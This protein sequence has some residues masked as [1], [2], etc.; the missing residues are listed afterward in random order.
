MHSSRF[1][2][3]GAL[4]QGLRVQRVGASKITQMCLPAPCQA[5]AIALPGMQRAQAAAV[6]HQCA[7]GH[8][9]LRLSCDLVARRGPCR[10]PAS[11]CSSQQLSG[12]EHTSGGQRQSC[13]WQVCSLGP[14]QL[15]LASDLAHCNVT[16]CMRA[17]ARA[18][19][20][21]QTSRGLHHY[22][23]A[24]AKLAQHD[25]PLAQFKFTR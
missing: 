10:T 19:S 23:H 18:L 13:R 4:R 6:R 14:C 25:H 15:D 2:A 5:E 9:S 8:W 12:I 20:C 7:A 24:R 16:C 22:R 11:H 1:Q 21:M 3:W 17:A